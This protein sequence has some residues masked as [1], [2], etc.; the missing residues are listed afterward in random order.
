VPATAP[1][2]PAAAGPLLP[3]INAPTPAPAPAPA[4]TPAPAP[5]PV[6]PASAAASSTLQ[7][8]LVGGGIAIAALGSAFA[9]ALHT[10]TSI[11]PMRFVVAIA[12]FV[13]LIAL[14]SGFLGWL[15]LR[16]R[17]LSTLL[18]ACGWAFNVRIYLTRRHSLR[19]T[20]VPPLPDGSVRQ[21]IVLPFIA[22]DEESTTS[23]LVLV[24]LVVAVLAAG[25]ILWQPVTRW[26]RAH[27]DTP[28]TL[29]ALAPPTAPQLFPSVPV[30]PTPRDAGP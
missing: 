28:A 5:A 13:A 1:A 25:A 23:G 24:L 4:P 30:A 11:A 18:E 29:P 9:F 21:R 27:E 12:G 26:L 20:R 2:P 7:N 17:D 19:F 14:L 22:H 16:R 6:V 10:L 3:F 15:K 8:T